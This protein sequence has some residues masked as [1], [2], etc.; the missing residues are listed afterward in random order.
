MTNPMK[1]VGQNALKKCK[2]VYVYCVHTGL[3]ISITKKEAQYIVESLIGNEA[4]ENE[5]FCMLDDDK[6]MKIEM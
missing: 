6:M 3:N 1:I 2:G 4:Y 5:I